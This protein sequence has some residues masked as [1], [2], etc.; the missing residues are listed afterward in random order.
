MII[1]ASLSF[2]TILLAVMQPCWAG[3]PAAKS[4]VFGKWIVKDVLC[5]S[6]GKRVPAEKGTLLEF[7]NAQIRNPLSENCTN[8]PGYGLLNEMSGKQVIVRFGRKW[9]QTTKDAARRYEKIHYGFITCNGINLMQ[10]LF[11]S[12]KR[13]FYF[14]EGGIVFDLEHVDYR[15][16]GR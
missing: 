5:S 9:P 3:T 6:C 16:P 13:A 12:D 10:M 15:Q 1:R 8:D 7:S 11:L 14:F 4:C 2:T